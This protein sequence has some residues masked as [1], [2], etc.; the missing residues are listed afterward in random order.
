MID[1]SSSKYEAMIGKGLADKN[2]LKVGTTFTAY[3]KTIIVKAIFS[4]DNMFIDGGIIMPLSI[5]QT[6]TGQAGAVSNA[7]A[8]IDSSENVSSTITALKSTLGDKADITNEEEQV[9][10]SLEPLESIAELAMTGVA[11]AAI[12]GAAIILLTMIMVVRERRREIGVIKAIGGTNAKVIAQFV[13]EALTLTITGAVI[14]IGLGMLVSGPMTRSFVSNSSSNNNTPAL[15]QGGE[16]RILSL[17]GP[18]LKHA[19]SQLAANVKEVN[20]ILTPQVFAVSAG[21]ILL[22]AIIGS[23]VP[24]W[25]ISRIRPAEVLRTE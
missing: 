25:F 19:G 5:V 22:V 16:P 6:L 7:V 1:G 20:S 2:S 17:G 14:G 13:S 3:G 12:A 23:A 18:G 15:E 4:T 24:A 21:I 8:T 9:K 11:A 10:S